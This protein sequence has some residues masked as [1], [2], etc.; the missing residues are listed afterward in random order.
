MSRPPFCPSPHCP[1]HHRPPPQWFVR[2]GRYRTSAFG[3]VQRYSCR[4]CGHRFSSQSFSI[5][6][7]AKR[8][9]DYHRLI[10]ML[11]STSSTRDISRD[12][13]ISTATVQNKISR[14][15]RG[16][17]AVHA[18]LSGSFPLCEH[19]VFDGF[20]SFSCSHYFPNNIHLLVGKHSQFVY[21]CNYVS[22]RRK[23]R[24][25]EQQKRRRDELEK[26]YRPPRRSLRHSVLQ[27]MEQL[28]RMI[29]RST[30]LPLRLYSDEKQEYGWALR[31]RVVSRTL[32]QHSRL[33]HISISS[34]IH[35]DT[36]NELFSVNYLDRELRKDLANHVRKTVCFARN[37]N[38]CMERVAVYLGYHNYLKPYRVRKPTGRT[39]AEEA[40]VEGREA[41]R[42]MRR[43]FTRRFFL[44]RVEG[45]AESALET[46]KRELVTPLKRG[47]EYVPGYALA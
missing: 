3:E 16:A 10:R 47:K 19:L 46:W 8:R 37:V 33:S 27:A 14:L 45:M 30:M 24:M 18:R 11:C 38:N 21:F 15:A 43:M 25:S 41:R 34:R 26:H 12:L 6:Y 36:R 28:I 5:D 4:H 31:T 7:F 35:R 13:R 22:L 9:V 2:H 39:H 29:P 40:G 44:S 23:G 42:M 20:E 17:L 1:Y 32:M